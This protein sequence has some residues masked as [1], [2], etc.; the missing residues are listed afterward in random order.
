MTCACCFPASHAG[1]SDLKGFQWTQRCTGPAASGAIAFCQRWRSRRNVLQ[2][3]KSFKFGT[4]L[5]GLA[6]EWA[7]PVAEILDGFQRLRFAVRQS[8][9]A[10]TT[11][12][13]PPVTSH[14]ISEMQTPNCIPSNV[15]EN[16]SVLWRLACI[17]FLFNGH[18]YAVIWA[19]G[20]PP[21]KDSHN[22]GCEAWEDLCEA[23]C[24]GNQWTQSSVRDATTVRQRFATGVGRSYRLCEVYVNCEKICQELGEVQH[25][26]LW[27]IE[28]FAKSQ[29]MGC[30]V[31][32]GGTF[33]VTGWDF[34]I[35]LKL[36]S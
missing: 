34:Q 31:H 14:D 11:W 29:G 28:M 20:K 8:S 26:Q 3:L 24:Q 18:E 25:S 22:P 17:R 2:L 10:R 16:I 32:W 13:P 5:A 23:F 7:G 4:C 19:K 12:D 33:A 30:W 36:N 21:N 15:P 27:K 9:C 1:G 35:K 6:T